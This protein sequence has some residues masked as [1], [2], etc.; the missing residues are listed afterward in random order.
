MPAL[1]W[2]STNVGTGP[3]ATIGEWR[4]A[5]MNIM[6]GLGLQDVS[7]NPDDI[8]GGTPDAFAAVTFIPLNDGS[9][10]TAVIMVAGD[11]ANAASELRTNI[12]NDIE[13]TKFL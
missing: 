10:Y 6:Q 4:G 5:V 8:N 1:Y 2:A 11:T 13:K 3:G 9:T 12:L 7:L